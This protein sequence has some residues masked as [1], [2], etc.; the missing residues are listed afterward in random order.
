LPNC[1]RFTG[2]LLLVAALSKTVTLYQDPKVLSAVDP[3]TGVE[4]GLLLVLAIV[5]EV[6]L[7]ITAIR[8]P[9]N[10]IAIYGIG[11]LGAGLASYRL[12]RWA[13]GITAPCRCLGHF[14]DWWP[15]A[16]KHE[17]ELAVIIVMWVISVSVFSVSRNSEEA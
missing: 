1:V 9:L 10:L 6:F 7:G 5:A 12:L 15:W 4:Y 3:L 8:A 2:L 16:K 13:V 14:L 17:E 11:W